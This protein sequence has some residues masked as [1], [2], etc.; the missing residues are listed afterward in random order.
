M[1]LDMGC[2]H[3]DRL[4]VRQRY[5]LDWKL[6]ELNRCACIIDWFI[7]IGMFG[8]FKRI[9]GIRFLG[10]G[11]MVVVKGVCSLHPLQGVAILSSSGA[12][13]RL[14]PRRGWFASIGAFAAF[15]MTV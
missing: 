10:L 1:C 11:L 5:Q 9:G 6:I 2:L 4:P 12:I 3:A 13:M 8:R 15:R 7:I 14:E